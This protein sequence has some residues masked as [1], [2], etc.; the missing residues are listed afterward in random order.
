M[1]ITPL[2]TI[3]NWFKTG[4]IP[5]QAQFWATWDSF[6]H[7]SE[8]VP[9]ADV[10]GIDELLLSKAEQS[11]LQ[12]HID[13]EAAHSGGTTKLKEIIYTVT[14][15]EIGATG[16]DEPYPNDIATLLQAYNL[17]NRPD[18]KAGEDYFYEV[19]E[20]QIA[21]FNFWLG[22]SDWSAIDITDEESF[23]AMLELDG[24][25]GLIVENFSLV[26]DGDLKCR[27]T[28]DSW[29]FANFYSWGITSIENMDCLIGVSEID[30]SINNID[31][32]SWNNLNSFA[33]TTIDSGYM[34]A[35]YNV[36][37]NFNTSTT[38]NTLLLKSWEIES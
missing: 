9:V 21:E 18:T 38:Y 34:I 22:N 35:E 10:D 2:N 7:K 4:L 29:D 25:V 13:D 27:I 8:K 16:W 33:V 32:D 28:Y 36:G 19:T 37:D 6:R 5:T 15:S 3:K 24:I 30:F 23:I 12:A 11:A 14:L 26:N 31:L 17:A 1:A 20:N